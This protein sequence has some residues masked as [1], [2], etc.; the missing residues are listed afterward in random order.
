VPGAGVIGDIDYIETAFVTQ[1]YKED[2]R[3]HKDQ[4][5]GAN[6]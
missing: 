6:G 4:G 2:F 3:L 5:G 1:G